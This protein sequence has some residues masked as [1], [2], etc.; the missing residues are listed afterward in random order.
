MAGPVPPVPPLGTIPAATSSTSEQTKT[1]QAEPQQPPPA[2]SSQAPSDTL[3]TVARVPTAETVARLPDPLLN[4]PPDTVIEGL[5][6]GGAQD[7]LH[8]VE[9]NY[10]TVAVAAPAALPDG[11]TV[12]L[13]VQS[14]SLQA[15]AAPVALDG[16]APPAWFPATVALAAPIGAELPP[17]L[18]DPQTLPA[19]VQAAVSPK[20]LFPPGQSPDGNAQRLPRLGLPPTVLELPIGARFAGSVLPMSGSGPNPFVL[21]TQ[22]TVLDL[23]LPSLGRSSGA[24]SSGTPP[25]LPSTGA[26]LLL[27]LRGF[28][29]HINALI[30]TQSSEPIP[31][32]L[33][34]PNVATPTTH[35]TS[36][37]SRPNPVVDQPTFALP[38]GLSIG[39][40]VPAAV[41]VQSKTSAAAGQSSLQPP[42][43]VT[44]VLQGFGDSGATGTTLAS[45]AVVAATVTGHDH[46]GRLLLNIGDHTLRADTSAPF[47]PGTTLTFAILPP[48]PAVFTPPGGALA[49]PSIESLIQSVQT[50]A[51]TDPHAHGVAVSA[52]A[53][54]GTGAFA[55]FLAYLFAVKGGD[56]RQWIGDRAAA[57][58]ER[59]GRGALLSRAGDEFRMV[60]RGLADTT[61]EWRQLPLP[62]HD[63]DRLGMVTAWMYDA[64]RGRGDGEADAEEN[65]THL[66]VDLTLSR[67]GDIR[68]DGFYRTGRFD[69]AIASEAPFDD[70]VRYNMMQIFEDVLA[71]AGLTGALTF[72]AH[73]ADYA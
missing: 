36:D 14:V 20:A 43:N 58:L 10:G 15:I 8:R 60:E 62:V 41:T 68:L 6:T 71:I 27:E 50:L 1:P 12:H 5:V 44:L 3:E 31:A 28:T 35:P 7:A 30:V 66:V 4:L 37:S 55:K 40:A 54:S 67:L 21:V 16:R 9:T 39:E 49:A 19:A 73:A 52:M 26:H 38:K 65:E 51:A 64:R 24:V 69:M 46:Q 32:S 11:H 56:T 59:L 72:R 45:G 25:V 33:R 53:P 29:Q 22:E 18:G 61:S 63:G 23:A 42:P 47:P 34:P 70:P 57:A 2:R 13:Q 17:L 48:P